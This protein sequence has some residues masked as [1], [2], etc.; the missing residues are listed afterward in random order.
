MRSS[1]LA[2]ALAGVLALVG[3]TLAR[4]VTSG[5]NETFTGTA[6]SPPQPASDFALTDNRGRDVTL[7]DFRGRAL[8]MFFG[9]TR[10]PDICPMTLQKLS[11]VVTRV[12]ADT[13]DLRILLVTVDPD[14]DTPEVLDEY[15]SRFGPHTVGLTGDSAA[16]ADLRTG[17]GIYAALPGDSHEGMSMDIAHTASVLGI[18]RSGDL[19]VL[20]PMHEPDD[21]IARD[22]EILL[23]R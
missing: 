18:D 22:V 16:L 13:M 12:G 14:R 8:L 10:C 4:A 21:V 11:R 2:I 19:R 23:R 20:L 15:L 1:R 6:Y 5:S 17:Y 7:E 3:F 9:Y